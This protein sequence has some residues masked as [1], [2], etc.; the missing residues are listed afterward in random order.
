MHADHH[1]R[2]GILGVTQARYGAPAVTGEDAGTVIDQFRQQVVA[3]AVK[4]LDRDPPHA[5]IEKAA[6]HG[7]YVAGHGRTG[8]RPGPGQKRGCLVAAAA[9][10]TLDIGDNQDVVVSMVIQGMSRR[11]ESPSVP[12]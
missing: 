2:I 5:G 3:G 11:L 4:V 1:C 8:P 12:G 7:I 10:A 6:D 9:A